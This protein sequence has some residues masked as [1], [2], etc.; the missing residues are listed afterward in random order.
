MVR[1]PATGVSG[2]YSIVHQDRREVPPGA[3]VREVAGQ[4]PLLGV[5]TD[6][7]Q[8]PPLEPIAQ[9][10]DVLKLL[11]VVPSRIVLRQP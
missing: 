9:R 3:G 2:G 6:D 5:N 10:G 11:V 7:G 4:L 8:A 1:S